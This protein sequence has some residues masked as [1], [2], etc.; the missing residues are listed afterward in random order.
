VTA[1]LERTD[2]MPPPSADAPRRAG[3][4]LA[5]LPW[6]LPAAALI[7][8]LLVT[9]TPA[10]SV[11]TYAVYFA[12]AIV[13]PGT[14][15]FR[16]LLGSRGNLPEDLGL[17]AATGL[18]V[19]LIG[20]ALCAAT[21]LQVLLPGW[22]LLVIALFLAVP[23]LRR[24]W[25][26]PPGRR[27]PLPLL[28]SWIV[29]GTLLLLVTANY[30]GWQATL[31]PPAT[32]R[33]YQDL[34]YHLAL[35]HEMTRSIPFQ[36]PQLVGDTLRYHYLSDADM[37]AASMITR[38]PPAV[39]LLRLWIVPIEGVTVFVVAALT[40]G[41]TG[42]WWAGALA[43]AASVVALPLMLGEPTG[44]FGG[45]PLSVYS[46]SQTYA[47]PLLG[48]LIVLAA[49]M[50]NGRRLGR[51]WV[52]VFPLALACAGAK[53]SA[54]PP[55][56]AGLV[57]AGLVVAW[58]Y[59]DR[60]RATLAFA[61]LTI[62]AMAVGLKIFAGGGASTLGLQPF[63]ILY[64]VVPYR[65]TIGV[66]D[67]ID[68]TRALPLGVEQASAGGV[69]F[70]AGLVAWWLLLQSPRLLGWAALV[71]KRTRVEPAAWLLAGIGAAGTG[72]AWLLWHPSGSQVYFY[73]CALPFATVLTVWLLADHARTWRPVVAGLAAGGLW[74]VAAPK[75]ASPR[76]NTMHDWVWALALPLLRTVAVAAAVAVLAL[77]VW[78]LTTG[79]FAW[80]A[81]PVGVI[82]AVLGAGFGGS[83]LVQ[84]RANH[85]AI[86]YPRAVV[87]PKLVITADEMRAALWLDKHAGNY[88][89]IAT[90][91]HCQPLPSAGACDARAFWVDGLGGRRSVVESWGY[92]DQ[93]LAADGVNGRRYQMQPAPYPDRFALNQRVFAEGDAADVA[94][95]RKEFHVK[96]LFADRRVPGGVAPGLAEV[97]TLRYSAGPV[98]V[99]QM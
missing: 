58:R 66:Q 30:P 36:V 49:E 42:K 32:T 99:Y 24:C 98:S 28:W 53:S 54:L 48:L 35:V 62:A 50:L 4:L 71:T 91:V 59:R 76:H 84:A 17:G 51:A 93:A 78:R 18:L 88:D 96:W 65:R 12:V 79:R 90:N 7:V 75:V 29:A 41:L 39:V 45:S 82:A 83:A 57:L 13:L 23:R 44:A 31:L 56:V 67:A 9:G 33:Y 16:A 77:V 87:S 64:G 20:W 11:A 72:G 80:R 25:R 8:A 5:S 74:A 81:L 43:G 1:V 21:R 95:L 68:G 26:I 14:L 10:W 92:T 97:T 63:A 6:L 86:S 19:L 22:P 27:K 94:R 2:G 55:F 40:R 15:V 60:L 73:L 46:P 3:L 89:V 38:I 37:A 47:L 52:M 85:R 70:I 61:G 34:M 69:L